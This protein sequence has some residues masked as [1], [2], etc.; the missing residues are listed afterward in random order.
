M[1]LEVVHVQIGSPSELKDSTF[2][3]KD[4]PLTSNLKTKII[5][6]PSLPLTCSNIPYNLLHGCV[7]FLAETAKMGPFIRLV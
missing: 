7:Q 3:L 6:V 5:V 1:N 4:E 2:I